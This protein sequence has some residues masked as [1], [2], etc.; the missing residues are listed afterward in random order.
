[1]MAQEDI[2][3]SDE[4]FNEFNEL[5]RADS[6][7]EEE[8]EF[9]AEVPHSD[10]DDDDDEDDEEAH[11]ARRV[12]QS[13]PPVVRA[14]AVRPRHEASAAFVSGTGVK[15]PNPPAKK[16]REKSATSGALVDPGNTYFVISKFFFVSLTRHLQGARCA[17]GKTSHATR[18]ELGT[19]AAVAK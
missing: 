1:M 4:E 18:P 19:R 14:G 15:P 5:V 2:Q 16:K 3:Y 7:D 10:E 13:P 17:S 12:S 6:D 8:G 11:V 9:G